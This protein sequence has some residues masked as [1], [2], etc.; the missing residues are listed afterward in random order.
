VLAGLALVTGLAVLLR[1]PGW[2]ETGIGA[3]AVARVGGGRYRG[4]EEAERGGGG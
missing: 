3:V 4:E 2:A 1:L